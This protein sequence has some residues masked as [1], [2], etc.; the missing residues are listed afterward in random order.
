M[1]GEYRG[2]NR[3]AESLG[4][5]DEEDSLVAFEKNPSALT[6]S[7]IGKNIQTLEM[8]QYV[9]ENDNGDRPVLKFIA[10]RLL[11]EEMCLIACRKNGYNLSYIPEHL[12]SYAIY[13]AAL[14]NKGELISRV[15]KELMNKEQWHRL[16]EKAIMNNPL[17]I[18]CM[19]SKFI[20]KAMAHDAVARTSPWCNINF[21]DGSSHFFPADDWPI[22]HIP[23]RHISEDLIKLS[24]EVCPSSLQG[25]SEKYMSEEQ[26]L[27]FVQR[28]ASLYQ[29]VPDIYKERRAI[30]DAALAAWPG[31]LAYI[32]EA[33]RTKSR[34]FNAIE[35]DPTISIL[36][37]PEKVRA[38]YEATHGIET[39]ASVSKIVS[40]FKCKPVPLATPD[41]PLASALV[42]SEDNKVMIHELA[43][44]DVSSTQPVYY[45]SDIHLEHQ[46]NLD[47]K[48]LTEVKAAITDKISELV[49]SVQEKRGTILIAGDVADSIELEE[50]FYEALKC[51]LYRTWDLD[52][53]IISVLGNHELW[54]GDPLGVSKSRTVDEIIC[55]Y[56]QIVNG[57]LL[58]NELYLKYKGQ[59]TVRI[60]EKLLLEADINELS[61]ICRKSTL[62][63]LGGI[64]FSGLNPKFNAAMGLYR[65]TVTTE[66][67]MARSKRF[68]EVYKKILQCAGMQQVIVLTHTQM[69]DWSYAEYNPHWVYIH[70]HTHQ[71]SL[72]RKKDGTTVLSDNQVG[73]TAKHWH[74]NG[75]E[76]SGR[77]DPFTDWTDGIYLIKPHQYIEFNR[78]CGIAMADF[79][80]AGEL[81]VLKRDGV[82]MFLLKGKSLYILEGGRIHKVEHDID[83]YFNNLALYHQCV[84]AAFTPY[85]NALKTL[86]KEVQ[87]FGGSG[88]VHGCIVDIDFFNHIYLNPFN[89]KITP[90][91]AWDMSNKL[92]YE[93][94]FE[95]LK[96]SP[97]P[98]QLSDGT[99]LLTQYKKASKEGG[100]PILLAQARNQDTMLA[101]VPELVLDRSI[102]E[103]SRIMRSVQYIFDWNIV[104]VW[105]DEILAADVSNQNSTIAGSPLKKLS[106]SR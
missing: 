45:I 6:L 13:E 102:Y 78:G 30:I 48:T 73:Y 84:K 39:T 1:A 37:F 63:V 12:L 54:D 96:D 9:V 14:S 32:P 68:Q 10:K 77:Y 8:V 69:E 89:G 56:R 62:I 75:F 43:M 36:L 83:Y 59:R 99:L 24:V 23:K 53:T 90:Y 42:V 3:L 103:P 82:Y 76:V 28:D 51:V 2:T 104:R 58:E 60:D 86:S 105:K 91:F 81:Y 93:N 74:F 72:I 71:N 64:G 31:A 61:E 80:R 101:T 79:K 18:A 40:S 97:Y 100:L 95:L 65:N 33:K 49:N 67:D 98:P 92:V 11:T 88:T 44:F 34:C 47:G 21:F 17:A 29:W 50:L 5:A 52:T 38:E 27:Q 26:C 70:G 55:E 16:C 87:A 4:I 57:T 20:T 41:A 66:E 22:S 46:L 19:P 35:R 7:H 94:I 15:P 106:N 25:V 85:Q